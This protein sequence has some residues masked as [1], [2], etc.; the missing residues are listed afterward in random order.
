MCVEEACG[1]G[2]EVLPVAECWG[3]YG[4]EVAVC[5]MAQM[6]FLPR[7]ASNGWGL[8]CERVVF[9]GGGGGGGVQSRAASLVG[10]MGVMADGLR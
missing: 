3:L 8:P 10:G 9:Q 7:T 5:D 2:E 6:A 1:R 4:G